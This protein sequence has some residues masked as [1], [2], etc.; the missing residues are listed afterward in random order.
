MKRNNIFMWAY[1]TF[2]IASALL[3][4]FVD[5]YLWNP[6]V[7]AITVS[8]IF[9]ALED[10]FASLYHSSKDN[11]EIVDSFISEIRKK[12][13]KE[14]RVLEKMGEAITLYEDSIQDV[15]SKDLYE[16]LRRGY[17]ETYEL[18]CLLEKGNK[19]K[20]NELNTYK[21]AAAFWSFFGFLCLFCTLIIAT[22]LAVPEIVQEIF[23][24]VP[25]ALILITRQLNGILSEK[26]GGT[27]DKCKSVLESQDRNNK[28]IAEVEEMFDDFVNHIADSE[29]KEAAHAD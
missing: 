11:L 2:I 4:I 25:F 20:R 5:F 18:I 1:I 6:I 24:V 15:I 14:R 10:L 22:S 19:E 26:N 28:T 23:T 16:S 27:L 9:F 7:L 21:K 13:D 29:Q 3:R 17:Q 12:D 8:G